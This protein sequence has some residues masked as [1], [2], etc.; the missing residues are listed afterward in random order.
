MRP[1]LSF[2]LLCSAPALLVACGNKGSSSSSESPSAA[3]TASAAPTAVARPTATAAAPVTATAAPA[4]GGTCAF[5]GGWTG[6]YPPGP[7]PFSGTPFEFTFNADGSGKTHSQR[8]DEEFAWKAEAGTFSIHGV[9][10]AK[11]GR[12]TC[13]LEDVGKYGFS[14]TPDCSTV[15]LKLTEDHCKGRATTTDGISLKRK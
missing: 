13:R 11:G 6:T 4:A 10:V 5:T 7:Y 1:S 2:A 15:T 8:A 14:F 9:K 3:L 12:F